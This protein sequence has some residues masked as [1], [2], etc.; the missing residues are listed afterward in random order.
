MSNWADQL[1]R[2]YEIGRKGL[3]TMKRELD[4][5]DLADMNDQS[6]IN[7]MIGTMTE[8]IDW[9]TIGKEPG[10]K[11]GID[12]RAAYQRR[13]M[14]DMDL[15]PSLDIVPK[16][17]E[18]TEDEKQIIFNLIAELSP[19]ERQ[20]F[21]MN[22]AYMMSYAEISEEL[23]IGRSTVQKYVERARSKISCRT[24]VVQSF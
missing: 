1:I 24:D 7:S 22:K 10:K 18:L 19:R 13:A 5:N 2:E 14:A 23:K 17:R 6:K 21:I 15:F 12:K 16:E 8:A 20:C 9:M 3:T 4:P 11:R